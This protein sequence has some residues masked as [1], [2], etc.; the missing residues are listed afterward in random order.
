MTEL[1]TEAHDL[2]PAEQQD[3]EDYLVNA[4]AAASKLV[5]PHIVDG[6]RMVKLPHDPRRPEFPGQDPRCY[7]IISDGLS[8][9]AADNIA[10]MADPRFDSMVEMAIAGTAAKEI[11]AATHELVA[12]GANVWVVT[13]HEGEITDL[14]YGN[15]ILVNHMADAHGGFVPRQKLIILSKAIPEAGY[16][17]QTPEMEEPQP[18][19][20]ALA[21][22]TGFE[23]LVMPWPKTGSSK[24]LIE[25][26]LPES[27]VT[28]HN[29]EE[30]A[31][32]LVVATFAEGGTL[33]AIAPTG[34][35]RET[36]VSD[37]TVNLIAQPDTYILPM[38]VRRNNGLLLAR[39]CS[40]PIPVDP[41][42]PVQVDQAMT[43][44]TDQSNELIPGSNL[45]YDA[46]VRRLGKAALDD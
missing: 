18:V 2:S 29:R 34:S 9:E 46:P 11:V 40:M 15:K 6:G 28:R 8:L 5:D 31:S 12:S 1:L 10:R 36:R 13:R 19:S 16:L 4:P 38:I 44:I 24:K 20:M 32:G 35:T 42:N 21:T 25:D 41:E 23:V 7:G 33:G 3:R 14:A 30:G 27:E 17:M 26:Y 39:Y 45:T 37:A 43:V 22:S